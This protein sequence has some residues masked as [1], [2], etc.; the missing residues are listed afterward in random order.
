[1]VGVQEFAGVDRVAV[2]ETA[3][4][5]VVITEYRLHGRLIAAD[6]RCRLISHGFTRLAHWV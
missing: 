1:M 4:P 3:D 2:H 6:A 5:E